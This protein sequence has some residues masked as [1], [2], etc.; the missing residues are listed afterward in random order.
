MV[1]DSFNESLGKMRSLMERMGSNMTAYEAS[2]NE[3]VRI[4]EAL[5]ANRTLVQANNLYDVISSM[6]AGG[7]ASFGYVMGANLNLPTVKKKNPATNRMKSYVDNETL[8]NKLNYPGDRIGGIVKFT[9][10]LVHWSTPDSIGKKYGDYKTNFNNICDE[11]GC[12]DAKIKDKDYKTKERINYGENGVEHYSGN[13]ESKQ[14]NDYSSQNLHGAKI[15]STYLLVDVDGNIIREV[16]KNEIKDYIKPK[17]EYGYG[18]EKIV[19]VLKE[20][21]AEEVR[22]K[23][24]IDKVNGLNMRYQTFLLHSI[25]YI[26]GATKTPDG[27]TQKII[28]LNDAM[29]DLFSDVKVNVH[30]LREK[31]RQEREIDM[32][33]VVQS[34]EKDST[35]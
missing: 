33:D 9:R 12:E 25:L 23:E 15:K 20:L 18:T 21:G 7:Y 30:Q 34:T 35:L 11:Y 26:V 19:K 8:G 27:K 13:D 6:S 16:D 2:L 22:I 4:A 28:F 5:E 29:K 1:K 31:V 24:V 17:S 3:E 14:G 32:S 10:Y